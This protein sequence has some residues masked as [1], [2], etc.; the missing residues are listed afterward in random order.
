[1]ADPQ[2]AATI[3]ERNRR[4]FASPFGAVY[5]FYIQRERLARVV[6]RVVWH[7]DVGPFYAS[8]AAIAAMPDGST[9]VDAPCGSGV[10]LRALRAEQRVRYVGYDLSP[11]MLRRARRQAEKRG[12]A[13]V[14]LAEAD[15]ESLPVKAGSVDLFL[16][17]FGLHCMP[18]PLAALREAGRCLRPEGRLVGG[19][20]VLG[21]RPL[22]RIRVRPGAGAYG[23]VGSAAD[24]RRWL[25]EAGM[26]EIGIDVRGVFAY[27][28]ARPAG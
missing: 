5:A 8:M 4:V 16:S 11:E 3:R 9:V 18:D 10:A 12:L 1:V 28:E 23:P 14:E 13:Q 2:T 22:D 17:C 19:T 20:I 27:F 21:T 24:V 26:E 7:S 6:A 25:E 15:A